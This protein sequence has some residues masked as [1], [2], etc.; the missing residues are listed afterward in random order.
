MKIT[1]DL[2][3][4]KGIG[5]STVSKLNKANVNTFRQLADIS[6]DELS[7]I[8]G[9]NIDKAQE[10]ISEAKNHLPEY[11]Y[12]TFDV[13]E[14]FINEKLLQEEVDGKEEKIESEEKWFEDKFNYS[15]L[16]ASYPPT[17]VN[18]SSESVIETQEIQEH[19]MEQD[20][21]IFNEESSMDEETL[22]EKDFFDKTP[23][24]PEMSEG[25]EDIN[26]PE[27]V[28]VYDKQMEMKIDIE[29][30]LI[31]LGYYIIPTSV[32]SL[33]HILENIDYVACKLNRI[34]N[35]VNHIYIIPIQ[36]CDL[37]GTVLVD[38]TRIEYQ[39]KGNDSKAEDISRFR[40]YRKNLLSTADLIFN[41]ILNS[42]NF[43]NFFQKFFQVDLT[44]EKSGK[45][46]RLSFISGQTQY[47]ILI[48]PIMLCKTP[49]RCLEKSISFP[50][51]RSTNTHIVTQDELSQVLEFLEQKYQL[52]ENHNES[53]NTVMDYQNLDKK[54]RTNVRIT[55]IPLVG[56]GMALGV[57]YFTELF[58]L[59]RLLNNI[60]FAFIGIYFALLAFLY[61]KLRR[62]K[63]ELTK[64]F[65]TPYFLQNLE[66]SEVD[67]LE[68]KEQLTTEYMTQFGYECFGKDKEFK[69]LEQ[70]EKKNFLKSIESKKEEKKSLFNPETK[71]KTEKSMPD[72]V[73]N[74]NN[75]YLSFLED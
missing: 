25:V 24:V 41:D 45:K 53:S 42:N 21:E 44:L 32:Y 28:V 22:L 67:L 62:A 54:F 33:I 13:A 5:P 74:Y 58:S 27:E 14:I 16:S 18:P 55:S 61:I 72:E 11:N 29:D 56:Y 26:V 51:Q 71:E 19:P 23:L 73:I 20:D 35:G 6:P 75:K 63:K 65:E 57:V 17:L 1:E 68:F 39:A 70:I 40:N 7:V 52:I 10:F 49:P 46:R 64:E 47:K 4:I 59:L 36:I 12:E 38:E 30:S 9:V 34:S 15:R 37:E 50:Y 8:S 3:Q 48:E 43:R 66:Y 69:V 2:T 60:G 31:S